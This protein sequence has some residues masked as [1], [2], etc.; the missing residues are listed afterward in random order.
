MALLDAATDQ[1]DDRRSP[2]RSPHDTLF[3]VEV[4]DSVSDLH[5]SAGRD[6]VARPRQRS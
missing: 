1:L 3:V 4:S 6:H 2:W 5:L